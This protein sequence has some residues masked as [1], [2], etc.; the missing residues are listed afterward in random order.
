M[1]GG[2]SLPSGNLRWLF[3]GRALR[4]FGTAFLTVV[5]PLYLAQEGFRSVGVGAIL[6]LSALAGAGLVAAVGFFGDRFGRRTALLG[7]AALGSLSAAAIAL[8]GNPT[9]L[10]LGS[11]IG[12]VGRGGGAGSGGQWGPVLPAEQPLLAAS[13]PGRERTAVFGRIGFVGVLAG[14][15]GSLVAVVPG[16][17]HAAGWTWLDAYRVIFWIGA[18]LSVAMFAVTLPIR[19]APPR[20]QPTASGG[21]MRAPGGGAAD[22]RPG[23]STGQLLGRLVVTNGVNGL[24]IGFLGPLL[25]YWFHVRYGVGS[26]EIGVLYT[27]INLVTALPYLGAARLTARLGAVRTVVLTRVIGVAILVG[28]ALMPTFVLAGIA[29]ALRMAFNSL[30]LPARQSYVM[31][32]ADERRRGMVAA[33]GMLPAQATSTI[34][35]IVGGILMETFVDTPLYGAALF[36]GLNALMYYYAFRGQPPPEEAAPARGDGATAAGPGD[37]VARD[38]RGAPS[39]TA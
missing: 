26:A 28:M 36:M 7:L 6:T 18:L 15:A 11:G 2:A 14:A 4:S 12:G 32:V 37:G 27:V 35:P 19:E 39:R 33:I 5:F 31:G 13:V 9:V 20:A 8:S 1:H 16:A 24:G 3:A 38:D 23:L 21:G 17:L 29:Y 10:V 22:A 34:S 25:T 30:G